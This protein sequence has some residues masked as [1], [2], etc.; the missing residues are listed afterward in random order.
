METLRTIVCH[1]PGQSKALRTGA[2]PKSAQAGR[3]VV[4]T[5]AAQ[6]LRNMSFLEMH[7]L[8]S[9]AAQ[10]GIGP[11]LDAW[12]ADGGELLGGIAAVLAVL[13]I[14]RRKR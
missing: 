6:K 7:D 2:V 5:N 1:S 3:K 8:A 12:W 4:G 9:V 13:V 11:L 14:K 10:T